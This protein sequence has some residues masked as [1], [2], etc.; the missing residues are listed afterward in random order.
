M[1]RKSRT[2]V[3][4]ASFSRPLAGAAYAGALPDGFPATAGTAWQSNGGSTRGHPARSLPF[5]LDV[6]LSTVSGQI[7]R[8]HL[9]GVFA[10]YA[11]KSEESGGTLG[12]SVQLLEDKEPVFRVD[13]LNGRHYSDAKDLRPLERTNGDGTSL[14]TV[15]ELDGSRVDL[16]S[17]DVPAGLNPRLLRIKDLGSPASFL[18]FDVFVEHA[19]ASGCPFGSKGGG[20]ALSEIPSIVRLGDRVKFSK[21]L[22]QLERS[23]LTTQE[24]D[25]ARGEALTF[26]AMVTAATLEMGGSRGMHREQLQAARE[27]DRIEDPSK[28]AETARRRAEEISASSFKEQQSPSSYL[29]DRALALVERNYARDLNDA[30]VADQLGLSTSH[31]RY[32]FKEA[33]GQP[34]HKYLVSLRLEKARQ[35]LVEGDLSVSEVARAVG[36]AGLSHFSRAFAQRF[37]VSPTHLRRTAE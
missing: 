28:L 6:D 4:A 37:A 18:I 7:E 24:L 26:L 9:L 31:F 15:G 12:A 36:F 30:T 1:P 35:M 21:A 5:T 34:F 17:I 3:V 23:L 25:E 14:L 32:L 20:I 33:T 19:P 2:D 8:I 10:L 27:F 13:L 16:L 11:G 22:D 29:V